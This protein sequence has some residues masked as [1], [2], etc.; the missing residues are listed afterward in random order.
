[1]LRPVL[2]AL[3]LVSVFSTTCSNTCT[4]SYDSECDDGGPNSH[5]SMCG[6]GHDCYDCGGRGYDSST[7]CSNTCTWSFDGECD[8]GGPN[9]QYYSC[10]LGHDC[11][12]CGDRAYVVDDYYYNSC[13]NTCVYHNDGYCDDGGP[14]ADYGICGEGTDCF[15][16]CRRPHLAAQRSECIPGSDLKHAH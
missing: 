5:Y 3:S 7:T 2:F 11:N 13:D 6:L 1:M 12:D 14:G 8:D 15:D 9:S 4:W 16:C 10:G